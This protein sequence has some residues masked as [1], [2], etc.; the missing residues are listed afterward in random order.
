MSLH[1]EEGL[2]M[3]DVKKPVP[4]KI[5]EAIAWMYVALSVF[6]VVGLTAVERVLFPPIVAWELAL[7][8]LTVGMVFALRRGLRAYFVWPNAIVLSA[9]LFILAVF[10]LDASMA[11]FAVCLVL[12]GLI[13]VPIA[14]L[15]LPSSCRWLKEKAACAPMSLRLGLFGLIACAAFFVLSASSFPVMG[16]LSWSGTKVVELEM[17]TKNLFA[18][19]V[20]AEVGREVMAE[21]VMEIDMSDLTNSTQYVQELFEEDEHFVGPY[22]NI[23]CIAVNAPDDDRFPVLFTANIDPLSLLSA[24]A[25]DRSLK[26]TCPKQW[27]GTRFQF[28][29]KAGVIVYKGGEEQIIKRRSVRPRLIFPDGIPHPRPDTY[30]LTPTGRVDLVE[31]GKALKR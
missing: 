23:W 4:V 2:K 28:C 14:L 1:S 26:L 17:A 7:L 30:F 12:V 6:L 29:E 31:S 9:A 5:V 24:Q 11:S 15:Y 22:T 25:E 3:D 18:R 27:Y 21:T 19:L 10:F 16:C 20:E 13:A 8:L